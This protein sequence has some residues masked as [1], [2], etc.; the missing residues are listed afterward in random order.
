[1]LLG[2]SLYLLRNG[3]SGSL[4]MELI[5]KTPFKVLDTPGKNMHLY[6]KDALI[7]ES[8]W[9]EQSF[10]LQSIQNLKDQDTN[11]CLCNLIIFL[12]YLN[13]GIPITLIIDERSN[14]SLFYL[15]NEDNSK[16]EH[17]LI[18]LIS[19]ALEKI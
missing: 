15:Y 17:E 19:K 13:S 7:N 6:L 2:I 8:L 9:V 3:S 4:K 18:A 11:Q 1:M 12:V 16:K 5:G 10:T 14:A